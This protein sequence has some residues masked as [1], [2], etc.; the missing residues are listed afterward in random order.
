MFLGIKFKNCLL[1]TCNFSDLDLK[2]TPFLD[3]QIRDTYFTNTN[4]SEAVFTGSDLSRSTFHNTDL[5]KADFQGA[6]NY[7]INPLTNKVEKAKFSKPEALSL[8]DHLG[9]LMD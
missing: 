2:G 7:S 4:L 3:C 9:I 6:T 1:E 5:R 8:L